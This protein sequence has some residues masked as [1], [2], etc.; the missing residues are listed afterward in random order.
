MTDKD[1]KQKKERDSVTLDAPGDPKNVGKSL[2]RHGESISKRDHESGHKAA[3]KQGGT[4]RPVGTSTARDS[5]GIDPEDPIDP[6]SPN[7]KR[8]GG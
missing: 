6:K 3:G 5:T 4:D 2:G 1:K 8:G 7:V